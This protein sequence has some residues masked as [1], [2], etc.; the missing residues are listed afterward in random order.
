MI[1]FNNANKAHLG[2]EK[3]AERLAFPM[4]AIIPITIAGVVCSIL[5]IRKN[6]IISILLTI[7]SF[8]VLISEMILFFGSALYLAG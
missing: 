8:L 5:E 4:M 2:Q 7:L 6:K 3:T 1:S